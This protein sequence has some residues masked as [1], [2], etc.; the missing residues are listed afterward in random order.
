MQNWLIG[1]GLGI[2]LGALIGRAA[3]RDSMLQKPIR[4]G[5]LAKVLH[6]VACSLLMAGAPTALLIT[7]LYGEAKFVPR[8]LTILGVILT[9]LA[10]A[11][12]CLIGYAAL[13]SRAGTDTQPKAQS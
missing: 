9:N 5:A 2:I 3:A 12:L 11:G 4:G 6:Y 13:E 7:V 10:V 1:W 8:L